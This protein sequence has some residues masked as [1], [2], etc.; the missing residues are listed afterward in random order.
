MEHPRSND[1]H[2]FSLWGWLLLLAAHKPMKMMFGATVITL[3]P[4]QLIT[5]RESLER[6]TGINQ[7]KVDRLIKVLK[8]EQQIEQQTSSASRL[9]TIVNWG[10]YQESEQQTAQQLS[11]ECAAVEQQL[12]T[13]KNIRRK[14]C[15]NEKNKVLASDDEFLKELQDN[16]A[17]QRLNVGMEFLRAEV[18]CRE[19]NRMLTRKFF[20]NWLNNAKPMQVNGVIGNH[21]KP[22][23]HRAE[24]ANREFPETIKPKI[25]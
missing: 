6:Q 25:L 7:H 23:D 2:W 17:Y 8:S 18:W 19:N 16:L 10:K 24:K 15:K 12:S 13:N 5:S 14:E 22:Q 4:G 1:P 9:I 11:S 3:N 21:L 20:A